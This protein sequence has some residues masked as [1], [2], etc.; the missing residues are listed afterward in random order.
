MP[1]PKLLAFVVAVPCLVAAACRSHG[2]AS[3]AESMPGHEA[4]PVAEVQRDRPAASRDLDALRAQV[5]AAR[6]AVAADAKRVAHHVELHRAG[7]VADPE[8]RAVE[9]ELLRS[10]QQLRLREWELLDAERAAARR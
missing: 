5:A 8:L 1:I 6:D 4:A 3:R 10:R 2:E 9:L 7:R